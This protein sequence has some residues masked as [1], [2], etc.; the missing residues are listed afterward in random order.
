MASAATAHCLRL[1]LNQ[2]LKPQHYVGYMEMRAILAAEHPMSRIY[3]CST[4]SSLV[5]CVTFISVLGSVHRTSCKAL[6][7][8]SV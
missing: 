2:K 7:P 8:H 6:L 3:H 1:D 5:K 4:L